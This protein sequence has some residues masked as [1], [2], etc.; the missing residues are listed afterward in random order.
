MRLRLTIVPMLA[1]G[2]LMSGAGAGL[3]FQGLGQSGDN[4]S[5]AQYGT[6]GGVGSQPERNQ[7]DR[8]LSPEGANQ[9][10]RVL[11]VAPQIDDVQPAR[12]VEAGSSLAS[13]GFAAIPLLLLGASL[14]VTGLI[15]HRNAP[16]GD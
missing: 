10:D 14:L 4:A 6:S 9:P 11:G 2:I 12:Q 15:L 1:V 7:P 13:T 5:V 8:P 16:R 3:A